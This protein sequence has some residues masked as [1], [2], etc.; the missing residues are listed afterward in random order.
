[1]SLIG[2]MDECAQLDE[3]LD[4]ARRG[5]GGTVV[6]RGEA[7]I[8]KTALIDHMIRRADD[9]LLVR[10]TGVE[11]ERDIAFAALHRL[12]TPILHQIERLPTPQRDALNSALGLAAG[13]P[14]DRFLLGL[15]VLSLASNA[16]RA[17]KRLLCV[18][19]DAQWIDRESLDALA[20]WGRRL[21]ADGTALVFGE[22][23]E[24][25][26]ST[27]LDGF[28]VLHL[29]G[30]A[31]AD[32]RELLSSV[33]RINLDPD[34]TE[35][36][37]ADTAGNPLALVELGLELTAGELIGAAAAP[38]PL[39]VSRRLEERFVRLGRTLPV[40]TQ[41]MLLLCAADSTGDA[42]F[43]WRA[44]TLVG[45]QASAAE[46]AEAVGLLTLDTRVAFR[47]P[48]IRSAVY[49][50]ARPADRR[51]VHRALA[52]AT[53]PLRDADRRA[54]HLAAATIG[55]DEEVALILERCA[56]QAGERG[57]HSATVALLSRAAELTPDP[58]RAAERRIAAAAAALNGGAPLQ[59]RT[60]IALATPDLDGSME[61]AAARRL[62]GSAW[63][64]LGRPG[65]A[66]P[67]LFSAALAVI[68]SDPPLGRQTL[69]ETLEAAFLAGRSDGA[70]GDVSRSAADAARAR[71]TNERGLLD[72]LL[73]AFACHVADGFVVAAPLLRD[74][75][76]AMRRDD[77]SPDDLVRWCRFASDA[78][79]VLW[80]HDAHD[81]LMA[82][83]ASV[84]RERGALSFLASALQ[85]HASSEVWQGRFAAAESS[86]AQ[87][88]DVSSAA[89]GDRVAIG[90]MGLS[91]LAHRGREAEARAR[92]RQVMELAAETGAG[93][94][95]TVARSALVVLDLGVGHYSDALVHARQVFDEDPIPF[96]NEVLANMVEAAVRCGDQRSAGD[97]MERLAERAPAAGT[98]WALGLSARSRAL[99]AGADGEAAYREAI[100]VLGTT[101]QVVESAR[102]HLLYGEW[103]RRQKRRID[104]RDE[105]RIA[106]DMFATMGAEAF[107]KRA[108]DELLATGEHAR[109][110][111]VETSSNLTP[112]EA[113]VAELAAAGGTNTEIA[114]QLFLSP[115]TV[116]YHLRKV[117]RKLAVTSRR[118]LKAALSTG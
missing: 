19:D 93:L 12:L 64:R 29:Q 100:E 103:L 65:V 61:H 49:A 7:G 75:V 81:E 80:D 71:P 35:R 56:A 63:T 92:A 102:S 112:Q 79:R 104:A 14:A 83:L 42:A 111:T 57:G 2:R 89:G 44:A 40:E 15:G 114:A 43:L 109:K 113:H 1:M 28:P 58:R 73:D 105:L 116:E 30:L 59:A 39:P 96:G 48:L 13:P 26:P 46:P 3:L 11:S 82:R 78:T 24:S 76:T 53:D 68:D 62:E 10:M 21:H 99:L 90:L 50:N 98:A 18:I 51:A 45:L 74:A 6:V 115:S 17:V 72:Q 23:D 38:R 85:S 69:L 101:R 77:V 97:A 27:S 37:I 88:V 60:L 34:V 118:Q 87:A 110:R 33:A 95:A 32:A 8:G 106:Y 66:A 41:M 94:A 117:F 108:R 22:R 84:T 20:F 107:A 25:K 67:I 5:L 52:A 36:I 70:T 86:I 16:V 4:S 47:H 55:S 9:F 54:W 91:I 31:D